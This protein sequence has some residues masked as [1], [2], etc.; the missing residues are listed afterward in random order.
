[1]HSHLPHERGVG[2]HAL[3]ERIRIQLEHSRFIRAV[4]EN[5][6]LQILECVHD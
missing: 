6:Y 2:G 4:G 3:D 1:M 5:F